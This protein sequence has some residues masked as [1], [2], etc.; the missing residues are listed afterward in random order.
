MSDRRDYLKNNIPQIITNDI[1][2]KCNPKKITGNIV[3]KFR[4]RPNAPA[5]FAWIVVPMHDLRTSCTNQRHKSLR[6]LTLTVLTWK[7]L[8]TWQQ[9]W[10]GLQL[11]TPTGDGNN[12][13]AVTTLQKQRVT[14]LRGLYHLRN[15]FL[16]ML[17]EAMR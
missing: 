1:T 6:K 5:S 13:I 14:N 9:L 17:H 7:K 8:K 12:P 11:G 15:T 4:A 10:K 3:P 2:T 16:R